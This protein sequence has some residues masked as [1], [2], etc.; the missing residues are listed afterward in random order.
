MMAAQQQ[1]ASEDDP[2]G[3]AAA[4]EA[5][6]NT[7]PPLDT[8][9]AC[10]WSLQDH[11][12]ITGAPLLDLTGDED[13]GANDDETRPSDG[14]GGAGPGGGGGYTVKEEDFDVFNYH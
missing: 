7:I 12:E 11:L 9:R 10:S 3:I 14:D 2:E 6:V 8:S 4:F 13:G 5:S 1:L